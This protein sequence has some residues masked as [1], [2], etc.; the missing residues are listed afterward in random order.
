[1]KSPE[2]FIEHVPWAPAEKKAARRAFD[3]AL[4]RHLWA[5]I[6]EAKRVGET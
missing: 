1:M 6:A 5:T 2:Q 3:Q 4:Q